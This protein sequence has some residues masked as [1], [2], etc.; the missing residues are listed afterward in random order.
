MKFLPSRG[1]GTDGAALSSLHHDYGYRIWVWVGLMLGGEKGEPL[2][3]SQQ[4]FEVS[5]LHLAS[6]HPP[7]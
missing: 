7:L 2:C 1:H 5:C 3:R 4:P 6:F